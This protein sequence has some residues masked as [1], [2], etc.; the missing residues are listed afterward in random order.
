[1]WSENSAGQPDQKLH[2]DAAHDAIDGRFGDDADESDVHDL[3]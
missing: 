2:F 1:M 3:P